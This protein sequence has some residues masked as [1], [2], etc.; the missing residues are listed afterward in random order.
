[1]NLINNK[2]AEM[3]KKIKHDPGKYLNYLLIVISLHSALIGINLIVLPAECFTYLNYN[4]LNEPF[5]AY[6]GGVFHIVMAAGYYLAALARHERK[7]FL[8]FIIIVKF[9]ATVFLLIYFAFE[10]Q[11]I[12]VLFSGLTD[13]IMGLAVLY[14]YRLINDVEKTDNIS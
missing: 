11:I 14:F 9:C 5:Y 12:I 10:K 4:E 6:Q 1:M 13:F 8:L 2:P 3:I 7:I